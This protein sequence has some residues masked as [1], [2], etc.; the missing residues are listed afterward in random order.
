VEALNFTTDWFSRYEKDWL[1][2]KDFLPPARPGFGTTM[3]EIGA[4]EGRSTCW[5]LD[6]LLPEDGMLYVIDS[7]QG[8]PEHQGVDM[9]AV[10]QRF[11]SNIFDSNKSNR[12]HL[13]VKESYRGLV[14]LANMQIEPLSFVYVDGGHDAR[15]VLTDALMAWPL[16]WHGGIMVFDDYLWGNSNKPLNRPKMAIDAFINLQGNYCKVLGIGNQVILRKEF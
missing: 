8:G 14:D 7:F 3:L 1:K 16:M 9:A 4:Y 6:N 10:R 11:F 5:I 2:L 15:T 12:V 13:L